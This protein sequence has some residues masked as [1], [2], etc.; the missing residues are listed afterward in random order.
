MFFFNCN[1]DVLTRTL[2]Q[3]RAYV[4]KFSLAQSGRVLVLGVRIPLGPSVGLGA[5][6]EVSGVKG[7]LEAKSGSTCIYDTNPI[8][9]YTTYPGGANAAPLI[10]K[11][12]EI[13][14]EIF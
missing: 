8:D 6:P 14:P 13:D 4:G 3:A 10:W 9:K 2:L 5:R 11:K 12:S 1:A 7:G